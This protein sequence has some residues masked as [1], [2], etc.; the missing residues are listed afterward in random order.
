MGETSYIL[1]MPVVFGW[2]GLGECVCWGQQ[3]ELGLRSRVGW[4]PKPSRLIWGQVQLVFPGLT[5]SL[6][7]TLRLTPGSTAQE[8]RG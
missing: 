1:I 7:I 5:L 8:D 3:G 2:W 4:L 6:S